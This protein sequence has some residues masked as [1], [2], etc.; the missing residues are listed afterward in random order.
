[1]KNDHS[2]Q[3]NTL[4]YGMVNRTPPRSGHGCSRAVIDILKRSTRR[5][6]SFITYPQ[7]PASL[8]Q[9]L[10]HACIIAISSKEILF[11]S[12]I[13]PTH[14]E[15]EISGM[16]S[17][18]IDK[19]SPYPL[20]KLHIDFEHT[21]YQQ[22]E[23]SVLIGAIDEMHLNPLYTFI[24]KSHTLER[25]DARLLAGLSLSPTSMTPPAIKLY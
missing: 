1:M 25:I 14:D 21:A 3:R 6:P 10:D 15:E 8:R 9:S 11:Q 4:R 2:H 12:A 24:Q 18:L 19:T 17:L 13:V 5:S 22:S 23:S 20:D 16:S 7:L